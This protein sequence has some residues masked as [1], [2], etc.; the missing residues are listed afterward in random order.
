MQAFL[1]EH[2]GRFS[3]PAPANASHQLRQTAYAH[4][5]LS[6]LRVA[7]LFIVGEADPIFPPASIHRAAEL[8]PGAQVVE[9]PGAAHSPYFETPALWN[10]AVLAFWKT[11]ALS[12][13]AEE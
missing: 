8:I 6:A 4:E 11:Q 7:T 13:N 3:G 9:I 2:I 1:Y 5:Q 10:T 12:R